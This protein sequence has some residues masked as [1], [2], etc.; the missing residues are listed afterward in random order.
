MVSR[1]SLSLFVPLCFFI[2]VFSFHSAHPPSIRP[3][4]T[5]RKCR[6]EASPKRNDKILRRIAFFVRGSLQRFQIWNRGQRGVPNWSSRLEST[7]LPV[8]AQLERRPVVG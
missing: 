6:V 7:L 3:V 5:R 2:S 4:D 1:L 8:T